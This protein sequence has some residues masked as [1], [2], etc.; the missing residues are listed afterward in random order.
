MTN[1]HCIITGGSSGIGLAAAK[2][3]VGEGYSVTLIARREAQLAEAKGLLKESIISNEQRVITFSAD[4]SN[5]NE[6]TDAVVNAIEILGPPDILITSAGMAVPGYF[7]EIAI[8]VYEQSM[9][10][11]YLGTIYTVKAALPH[12]LANGGNIQIVSSGAGL[13]GI[14]GY[15]AYSPTKFALRGFAES[16]HAEFRQSKIQVSIVYPPDTDTPQLAQENLTKPEETKVMTDTAGVWPADTVALE[17]IRGMKKGKF[18]ITPGLE[19]TLLYRIGSLLNPLVQWFW[20]LK[21]KNIRP[22]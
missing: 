19:L 17:M 14:F 22:R 1:K 10:V 12:M 16:L 13:I 5:R 15:T 6:I 2:K 11:N 7:K 20:S 9:A 18:A 8:E 21:I 3:L 4:V